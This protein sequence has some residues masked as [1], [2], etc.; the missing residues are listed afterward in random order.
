MNH[1]ANWI[2]S[3][4]PCCLT[5]TLDPSQTL[6]GLLPSIFRGTTSHLDDSGLPPAQPP[7]STHWCVL[8]KA[9]FKIQVRLC[10]ALLK[11]FQRFPFHC[12]LTLYKDPQ[13]P[14][15]LASS[16]SLAHCLVFSLHSFYSR[17][18]VLLACPPKCTDKVPQQD[19]SRLLFPLPVA[20]FLQILVWHVLVVPSGLCSA[21]T[22]LVSPA[23]DKITSLHPMSF[24]DLL[25]ILTTSHLHKA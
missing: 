12:P 7:A 19:L 11:I 21:L 20:L 5:G 25:L 15:N 14:G 13:S 9:A 8:S 1:S 17:H 16:I 10:H 22:F 3:W 4:R 23:V 24:P 6:P 2:H 18:T